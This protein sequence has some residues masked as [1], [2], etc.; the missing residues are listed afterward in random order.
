MRIAIIGSGMSGIAA[1]KTLMRFG[2]EVVLFERS[3]M[4]GGVWAQAYPEVRLQNIAEHYRFTDF[5]WPFPHDEQPP[6]TEVLRYINAA[7]NHYGLEVR[8]SHEIVGME[9]RPDGWTLDMRT[10]GGEAH[11]T[12]DYV[13]VAAGHYTHEK[14]PL[15]LPGA[16][17]FKGQL[18][19]ERD[20]RDLSVF[21]G[22]RVVV[23]GFGKSA[24]DMAVFAAERASDVHHVFREARWLMPMRLLGQHI[25]HLSSSRLSSMFLPAW[26]HPQGWERWMHRLSP[27]LAPIVGWFVTQAVRGQNGFLKMGGGA[28]RR[29]R[30]RLVNPRYSATKQLRGTL[31]PASYFPSIAEGKILPHKASVT[32]FTADGVT[33]SDGSSIAADVVMLAIGYDTPALPFL[34][35]VIRD[36]IARNPDGVQLYRHVLYPGVER[37]A[38]AGFNHN[39]FHIPGVELAMTWL[40]AVLADDM[41][42][43]SVDEMRASTARVRA[44]KRRHTVFEPTR[45]YWV[46]NRFHQ[47]FDALLLDL[48]VKPNRKHTLR[49]EIFESYNPEDYAG[50]FDEYRAKR[51]APRRALPFDT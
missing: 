5:D 12:F 51:G 15:R 19:T 39:A 47:Y 1:G 40:G 30:M 14:A 3:A 9:Q 6:A 23:V 50:V 13:I 33:L 20:V 37:L 29:A 49:A 8:T 45:A 25:A 26:T 43:P 38:F 27:V 10:A 41:V 22:K 36:D 18:V 2:H 46:A 16:E 42:L 4:V 21:G 44:W 24:I 17:T 34:P 31:A 11:E 32:G 28:P 35:Q 7:I 48:G